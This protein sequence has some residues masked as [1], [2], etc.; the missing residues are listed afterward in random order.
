VRMLQRR[1][2]GN[3]WVDATTLLALIERVPYSVY[4]LGFTSEDRAVENMLVTIRRGFLAL[5][6]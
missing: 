4:T 2:F 1:D 5:P 3:P 6:D